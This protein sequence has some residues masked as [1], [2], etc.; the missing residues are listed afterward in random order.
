[1]SP[2]TGLDVF[3]RY[4]WWRNA[5]ELGPREWTILAEMARTL[6]PERFRRMWHSDQPV[7]EAFRSEAGMELGDWTRDWSQRL[8][9]DQGRGPGISAFSAL[10]ALALAAVAFGFALATVQRRRVV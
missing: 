10:M 2:R 7:R 5:E 4:W 6:G 9:G 3:D 1:V 8:Y